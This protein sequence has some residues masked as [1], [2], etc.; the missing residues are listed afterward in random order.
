MYP[1]GRRWWV[2]SAPPPC[3]LCC[4]QRENRREKREQGR[5]RRKE[6]RERGKF[7]SQTTKEKEKEK[8]NRTRP[9]KSEINKIRPWLIFKVLCCRCRWLFSLA[10]VSAHPRRW[11]A[12][13]GRFFLFGLVSCSMVGECIDSLL[14]LMPFHLFCLFVDVDVLSGTSFHCWCYCCSS[15]IVPSIDFQQLFLISPLLCKRRLHFC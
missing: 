15:M 14:I 13:F 10:Q 1:S 6:E 7:V 5:K 9:I 11:V 3:V 12:T 2:L 4:R 8:T